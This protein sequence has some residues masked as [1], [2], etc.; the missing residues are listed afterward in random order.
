M[1]TARTQQSAEPVDVD[2]GPNA[3]FGRL[4]ALKSYPE[5]HTTI[6]EIMAS[7]T[8]RVLVRF[9]VIDG[10]TRRYGS[11]IK[12]LGGHY[13]ECRGH[14][15]KRSVGLP[16]TKHG[17]LLA[18]QILAEAWDVETL[19]G[20]KHLEDRVTMIAESPCDPHVG[21]I[22]AWVNVQYPRTVAEFME[23]IRAAL[24]QAVERKIIR[25]SW[26]DPRMVD[27]VY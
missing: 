24:E 13:S 11:K 16:G 5:I 26:P 18:D 23:K 27:H 9:G 1:I 17:L 10:F 15:N 19:P 21:H 4:K 14:Q 22:P 12:A 25:L 8:R 6:D 3:I 2:E 20:Y 7:L